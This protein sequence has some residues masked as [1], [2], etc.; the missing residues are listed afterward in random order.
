MYRKRNKVAALGLAILIGAMMPMSTM[1]AAEDNTEA[2]QE[3]ETDS[4]SDADEVCDDEVISDENESIDEEENVSDEADTDDGN[5]VEEENADD[6]DAAEEENADDENA[7]EEV[8]T[9][10]VIADEEAEPVNN[11]KKVGMYV[12]AASDVAEA[13][14]E[15]VQ[16]NDDAP[17][18]DIMW[19]GQ[20][21]KYDLGGKIDYIY[22][23]N[24][25][26]AFEILPGQGVKYYYYLDLAEK[27]TD[28]AKDEGQLASLWSK[29]S[30]R[31][32]FTMGLGDEQNYVL[33]VK[34]VGTDNQTVY[35]RSGGVVVDTTVPEIIGVEE[36]KIYPAG[37]AFTVSDANLD[38]VMV[39]EKIA[40]PE[41]DGS[42]RVR[43][44]G[45]SCLIRAKDKAGNEKTCSIT[46]I[47]GNSEEDPTEDTVISES[48]V[49]ALKAGVKYHL[50][51]GKWKVNGD[52]TVYQ[53]DSD[54][55][56]KEDGNYKFKK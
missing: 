11:E 50:A 4:V 17:V 28:P 30:E 7:A 46:V 52:K 44:N 41:S 15:E 35:A 43:A 19:D 14:A 56:V 33:Y 38:V 55:Y 34:A 9:D 13:G 36:G 25:G 26:K 48:K 27:V 45:T 22:V 10:D 16:V 39:N 31:D 24:K 1:L 51:A 3:M 18:I 6:E 32:S 8:D 2:T 29:D 37:T 21:S 53:G 23:N 54:F 20:S 12:M 40:A 5:T 47:G 42:Y 49:Y